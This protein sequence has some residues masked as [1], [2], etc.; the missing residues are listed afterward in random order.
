[1]YGSEKVKALLGWSS[2]ILML[3]SIPFIQIMCFDFVR[4]RGPHI[5][6]DAET[7]NNI[8]N[9]YTRLRL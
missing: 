5:F 8:K 7:M 1:M 4:P 3:L 6:L 9:I 2:Y